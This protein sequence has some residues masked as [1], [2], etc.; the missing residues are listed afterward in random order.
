MGATGR[1]RQ[2]AFSYLLILAPATPLMCFGMTCMAI[3]RSVGDAMRAMNVPLFGAGVQFVLEPP[4][5]F[6]AGLGITGSALALFGSRLMFAATGFYGVVRIHDMAERPSWA[7]VRDDA[8][9][10]MR[11]GVPA[12]ATNIATPVANLFTTGA[13]AAF[14]NSAVA[15]WAIAGRLTPLAFGVVFALSGAVSPIIGQNFGA[16][17]FTRVREA[18]WASLRINAILCAIASLALIIAEPYVIKAFGVSDRTADLVRF[19]CLFVA[20][21]F[22]FLGMLFV[23]NSA[24]NVLG[25]AHLGTWLNWG[26]ATLGTIPLVWLGGYLYGAEGAFLGSGLG[27]IVFGLLSVWLAVRILPHQN[28]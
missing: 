15:A 12:M 24:F 9:E 16:K 20:P 5:I 26:R 10:L 25:K 6:L 28:P 18:F 1:T 11:V 21:T 22:F 3:M 7:H 19:Y 17:N 8:V 4:L 13:I 14:G 27:G 2:L 23:T